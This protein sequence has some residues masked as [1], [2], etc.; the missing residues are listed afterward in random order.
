MTTSTTTPGTTAQPPAPE[1][2]RK[3]HLVL[4]FGGLMVTMLLASLNQTV[5][6]A[7]LPTIVG[8]LHGV[9]HM[10]WVITAFILAS[11]VMMPV[12]G[13]LGDM[14][15]RKPLLLFAIIVFIGGSVIG[16][17]A[18]DMN[19]LI[20]GRAIQ[21]IGGGGLMILSQA[22][23]ADVVPA[24]E[25][26]KYMGIMGGVFAFSSVAGP[27]LGG[28]LTE[29]PGWR[30]TFWMNIPLGVL[31]V[32]AAVFLLHI[33]R[34]SAAQRGRI[35]YLG[36][37]L[38]AV[39]TS[40]LV[41]AGTWGGGTYAWDSPTILGLFAAAAVAGAL[42]VW[43]ESRAAEPVLPLALFRNRNFNLTTVAGLMTGIAMFGAIGY[44]PTYLQ[45]V[46]GFG[47]TEAG[48]LMIPMMGGLLVTSV[49]V[50]RRVSV[51]GRYK[52]VMIT[53]T[54]VTALGLVLLSTIHA[55]APVALICAYLAV[56]GI[57]LGASMQ[58]LTLVAQNSFH[59]SMVGTATAGQ[60]YFRQ[61]GATLGSAV[62][63]SL[64]ASRLKELLVEKMPAGAGAGDG[65]NSLTPALVAS[66]PEPVRELIVA[67]YNE[68]LVPLFL[69]IAPL[70]LLAA[71]ALA[72]VTEDPLATKIERDLPAESLGEG[73]LGHL[74]DTPQ[75]GAGGE[76]EGA[77]PPV[78]AAP[79]S[80]GAA[81]PARHVAEPHR[82][83]RG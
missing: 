69:W 18:Q 68:A 39:A 28:W 83:A 8:E 54:L 49:L 19:V 21:G 63:G 38:L 60:N 57:G 75:G 78:A 80:A 37:A 24:R 41:L 43:V 15:G 22:I 48:L 66:L 56:M 33:P 29:G 32:L 82:D 3:N 44:M 67:S 11:T 61:V 4:L 30:W 55:D 53:G 35:D 25:R 31:A 26:G 72:F 45:M 34:P 47:P 46:T 76:D 77:T 2:D 36:M 65:G 51:T 12:Y 10:A 58:L 42:F 27:L 81:S 79:A 23:I 73:Q 70:A 74:H 62:V 59:L 52:A 1:A 50:G 40:A 7:A 64:F 9:E 16:A 13:K 6:A 14:F 17:L 5:L 71:L 20:L